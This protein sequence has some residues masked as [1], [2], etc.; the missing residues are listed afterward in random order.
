MTPT[1]TWVALYLINPSVRQIISSLLGSKET[2]LLDLRQWTT[3]SRPKG[4]I[5]PSAL[6][7]AYC[8]APRADG[9]TIPVVKLIAEWLSM[10]KSDSQLFGSIFSICSNVISWIWTVSFVRD[11]TTWTREM[12]SESHNW[13]N[14]KIKNLTIINLVDVFIDYSLLFTTTS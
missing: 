11:L 14:L 5:L 8:Q 6:S 2:F 4:S 3:T 10:P 13:I 12:S 9:R 7:V 1:T